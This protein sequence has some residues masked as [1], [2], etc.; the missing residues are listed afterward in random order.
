MTTKATP[1]GNGSLGVWPGASGAAGAGAGRGWR[2]G[3]HDLLD[4]V[5]V[6]GAYEALMLRAL[7][8]VLLL[9]AQFFVLQAAVGG[10]GPVSL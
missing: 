1:N 5:E 3:R 6:A 10:D 8:A 4:C 9:A 7:V 2:Y